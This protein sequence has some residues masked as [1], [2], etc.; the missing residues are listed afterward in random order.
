MLQ[1]YAKIIFKRLYRNLTYLFFTTFFRKI[2][3]TIFTSLPLRVLDTFL[4]L[5]R[6]LLALNLSNC[7]DFSNK[8][9][10]L[11]VKL[12]IPFRTQ[13]FPHNF[14]R[15]RNLSQ[16]SPSIIDLTCSSLISSLLSLPF[17]HSSFFLMLR[18]YKQK[19]NTLHK[20]K[21]KSNS[22]SFTEVISLKK[23]KLS[24][25]YNGAFL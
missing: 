13:L 6:V 15:H 3:Q 9:P 17:F 10:C 11:C 19:I 25:I 21:Q 23:T 8:S 5:L 2:F 20:I 12:R 18:C 16:F 1:N 24:G 7:L 22:A 14:L 4:T